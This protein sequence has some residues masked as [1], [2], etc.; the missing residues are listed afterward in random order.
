MTATESTTRQAQERTGPRLPRKVGAFLILGALL[1]VAI[2]AS[3]ALR[4]PVGV[5]GHRQRCPMAF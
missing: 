4:R 3:A 5:A 2:A 1:A